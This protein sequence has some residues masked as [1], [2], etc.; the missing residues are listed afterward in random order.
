MSQLNSQTSSLDTEEIATDAFVSEKIEPKLIPRPVSL[1]RNRDYLLLWNGQ[2]LSSIGSQISQ[3]A[4]PLL[5]LAITFSPAQAG[6]VGALRGLP[7]ALLCLPAGALVDRWDRK[8]VMLICDTGRAIAM[9]S[10]PIAIWFERLSFLQLCLVALVE[11]TLMTFFSI[12]E[13]TCLPHIVSKEQL[14]AATAQN[15][16]I[17]SASWTVGPFLGGLLYGLGR[18]VPFLMDALSYVCSVLGLLFV[19]AHFQDERTE[20]TRKIWHEIGEGFLWLWH[21][22]VLRF[23]AILACGLIMPSIGFS[24]ILI[25]LAQNQHASSLVIGILFASG[26]VGSILGA[27]LTDPL[28]KRFTFGQLTIGTA[29]VWAV[30]WL[31][32]AIAPNTLILGF[33]NAV[34]FIIVPIYMSTQFSY[35]LIVIPDA[36]QGRVQSIYRLLSFGSQPLGL[37][38]TGFLIQWLGPIWTVVVLF[39]PQ[40]IFA[41]AA[42]L[43]RP[44]REA[45][46]LTDLARRE[47]S[48]LS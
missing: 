33:A 17:D 14:P 48:N 46:S 26:G 41:L 38:L 12:A 6:I 9:G 20:P 2:L 16:A 40:G 15:Q 28:Q 43:Y 19:R 1:W 18:S 25:T 36:L 37:A 27:F 4:F 32:L 39:F 45:P 30:S 22:P 13:L 8:K 31:A 35:R 42:T 7:F 47:P 5:V 21:E 34:S 11:G 10:I 29:W 3:I 23:L 44:L 24:L